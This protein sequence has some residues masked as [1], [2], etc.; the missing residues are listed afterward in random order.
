M[1]TPTLSLLF[2]PNHLIDDTYIRL[3]KLNDLGRY[4]LICISWYWI[5]IIAIGVHLGG[6]GYCL[7]YSLG[8]DRADSE[9]SLIHSLRN[10]EVTEI[11]ILEAG[12]EVPMLQILVASGIPLKCSKKEQSSSRRRMGRM[13]PLL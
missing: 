7:T 3:D 5:W 1:R 9:D 2:P 12:G 13:N 10:G 6:E 4:V 8:G 11:I